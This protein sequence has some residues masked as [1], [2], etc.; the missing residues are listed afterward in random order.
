[1]RQTEYE[2]CCGAVLKCAGPMLSR[3]FFSRL[4][5]SWLL[6]GL[7][8][9]WLLSGRCAP[10][11]L[12]TSSCGPDSCFQEPQTHM[13]AYAPVKKYSESFNASNL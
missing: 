4:P 12:S 7:C 5:A 13:H 6:S 3:I 8:A 2:P 11:L 9:L 10:R 1:M